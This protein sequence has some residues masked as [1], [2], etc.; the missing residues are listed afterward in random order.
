MSYWL[1]VTIFWEISQIFNQ[2]RSSP[3]CR[4]FL[5]WPIGH[6]HHSEIFSLIQAMTH[7][8]HLCGVW[9]GLVLKKKSW[10]L[11]L[12]FP[13]QAFTGVSGTGHGAAVAECGAES[14]AETSLP[15]HTCIPLYF[16]LSVFLLLALL[17]TY[18]TQW[19][20]AWEVLSHCTFS[21]CEEIGFLVDIC[22]PFTAG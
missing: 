14:I 18:T 21:S 8:V 15:L 9:N 16:S 20:N 13:L 1:N 17:K 22:L 6:G 11:V 4:R 12:W 2:N 5:F 10:L 3:R 7:N 19:N